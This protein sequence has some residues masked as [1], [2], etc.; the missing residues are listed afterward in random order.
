MAKTIGVVVSERVS[1]GLVVD[2]KLV[3]PLYS[4][5]PHEDSEESLVELHTDALIKAICEQIMH[6]RDGHNDVAAVGVGIPGFIRAG[7]VEDA[8]N[9]PQ[10]KGA[11][12][13]ELLSAELQSSG[14]DCSVTV[15]ND[16][17][18]VAAG[19][20]AAQGKLDRFLRVWT[21]GVGIGFG[22][23]P[24]AEGVWEGGHTTVTLDEKEN[25]CGCGGRGHMEGH[26]GPSRDAP[27][28]SRYGARR[29]VRR[30]A[31]EGWSLPRLHA[32]VAHRALA[33]ATASSIHL[34]GAGKF[35]ITGF[36]ARFVDMTMLKDYISQMVKLSPLQSYMLEIVGD[37]AEMRIVGSAVAA[38][39][40]AQT[41]C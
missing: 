31:P 41:R 32:P 8:P 20:A 2:H 15:L 26:H 38:E 9:L 40:A 39:Q 4:Y 7:V 18:G 19:L 24:F 37:N 21:L 14:L 29:G 34:D 10:L 11:R 22:R 13:G 36:N 12:I 28:L 3:G 16:A 33:A 25:Y 1:A 17:D 23:Y 5:P 30:S 27:P 6:A 35:F